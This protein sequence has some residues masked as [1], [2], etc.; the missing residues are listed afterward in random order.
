MANQTKKKSFSIY[1]RADSLS[2][3]HCEYQFMVHATHFR[4]AVNE[5][6]KEFRKN[7]NVRGRR[8]KNLRIGICELTKDSKLN[9]V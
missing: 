4:L 9:E 8:I 5:A 7:K 6:L 1:V 3:A 2:A